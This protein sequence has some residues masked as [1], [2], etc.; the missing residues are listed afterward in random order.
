MDTGAVDL[1]I[2]IEITAATAAD[3]RL[4]LELIQGLAEYERLSDQVTATEEKLRDTLF[5]PQP[6]ADVLLARVRW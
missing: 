4:I 2:E 3:V 6:G 1:S 5:G